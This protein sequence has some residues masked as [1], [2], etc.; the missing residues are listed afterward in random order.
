[1]KRIARSVSLSLAAFREQTKAERAYIGN[2][3]FA[4]LSR[5]AYNITFLLFVD[6][7][8]QRVGGIAGYDKNDFLFMYFVSQF[9]FYVS[10]NG[11]FI[12]MQKLVETV[13]NGNFDLLL[14][15]P[16]PHRSFLYIG[17]FLPIDLL[18]NFAT[19]IAI[20]TP[21]I[22][23]GELHVTL[24][25]FILGVLVWCCGLIICNTLMFALALPAFK[26]G[27][28]TDML[29]VFYSITPMSQV[30]Y[31]QLPLYMKALSLGLLP[32]LLL[33]AATAEV[34]LDKGGTFAICTSVFAAGIFSLGLYQFL[35]RYAL[36]NYTSASS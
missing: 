30:P 15:K 22:H 23:W 9:G 10:F 33:S 26:L 36:R 27:D 4:I 29:N 25:S 8:F 17:G 34:M 21:F 35:W 7:L 11:I 18:F 2:F 5:I 6:A 1:M 20:V 31:N 16:V 13:R 19:V 3:W 14:L 28:A 24:L 32:Q 12:A